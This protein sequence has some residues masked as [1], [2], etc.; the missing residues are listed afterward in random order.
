MYYGTRLSFLYT[1]LPGPWDG[2]DWRWN[3]EKIKWVWSYLF[4]FE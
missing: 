2:A 4:K 3:F 1:W